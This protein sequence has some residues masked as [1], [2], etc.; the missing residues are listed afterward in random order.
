VEMVVVMLIFVIVIGLTGDA[1]NRI[2]SRAISLSR[3]AESNIT[4]IVGL[5]IMRTD[6]EAAGYGLLWSFSRSINYDEA[7]EDLGIAL[8]DNESAYAADPTQDKVP[9]AVMSINNN[10][11]TDPAVVLK[12]TDV[13]AVRGISVATNAAAK[14]WT[15]LESQVKPNIN[16]DP[17]PRLWT[18]SS[19][20]P[21]NNDRVIMV[22]PMA[23]MKPTN[24]LIVNADG[25]WWA[26]Y[27]N[28]FHNYS[29][30]GKP[31]VYNDAEGK[32]D[33]YLIYGVNGDTD[34]RMPFNRSDFYVR[35]PAASEQGWIRLPQRCNPATGILFKGVVGQDSGGYQELPLLDCVLDMQ[36]V[37]GVRTPGTTTVTDTDTISG[38]TPKDV[39]EQVKEIK[40]YIL[41]H[42]GGIDRN[43]TYPRSTIA[44]GPGDGTSGTGHTY[45]FMNPP[46]VVP[47]W[48]NYHWHVYQVVARPKNLTGNVAQ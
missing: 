14:R 11:F 42:N 23:N 26:T 41:T 6:L 15:Y 31:P 10:V 24:Q 40:V 46:N 8:N 13:L 37:Y 44:V 4:G 27:N 48:Q 36:V 28:P 39:R 30:I 21:A 35:R 7:S 12:G 47:N 1:F 38:F 25:T 19:D 20:N 34:L 32:S 45:D 17:V 33:L 16:P 43:Y 5:E 22:Q 18:S 2:V 29:T 3:S 9:H